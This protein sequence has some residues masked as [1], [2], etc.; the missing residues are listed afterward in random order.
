GHVYPALT[1][2]NAILA[3]AANVMLSEAKHLVVA[4]EILRSAQN[5]NTF[6]YLG[7][8][9]SVEERLAQRAE[10]PF[11]TIATG[12]V[13]GKAPW[14]VARSLAR[15]VRSV[16]AVR[17]IIRDVTPDAIFVTGGYVSAPVIWAGAAEK[18]PSVIYLP[19]LEPG[20]AIR[21][22]ARWATRVA[23][24]FPQ[25][26]R[27]FAPGKAIVTGYPVRREFFTTDQKRARAKFQLDPNVHA[28]AIF[29]GSSGAHH[30]NQAVV[31]NLSGLARRAQVIHLTGRNDETWVAD[32]AACLP[33][34]L[35]A[36]VRVF[37]YL[38]DDLPDALSAADLVV[39]RAGAATL[40]EFPALGLPAI[41]VPGPFAGQHQEQNARFLVERGAA[42][43]VDDAALSRELLP[44]IQ[45][46]FD[47]PEKLK[48]MRNAMRALANPNAAANIASLLQQLADTHHASRIT[49]PE[50]RQ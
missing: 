35:R 49:P 46:I 26:T 38:D 12:Q 20:W 4:D 39:A 48:T 11:R 13:R 33:D 36:R 21:V 2:V 7:R 32:Q 5:D 16:G 43:K 3:R 9:N 15:M 45:N 34:D 30:I 18:I 42:V 29:G 17:A 47:A 8:A 41:L 24:S 50:A 23:V 6:L 28:V 37:G 14:I 44:T 31:A 25:V 10:I 19:D 40:G 22:T 27:H 1:V